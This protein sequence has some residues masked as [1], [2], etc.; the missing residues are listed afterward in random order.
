MV[1]HNRGYGVQ[2]EDWLFEAKITGH[3]R[4]TGQ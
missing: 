2:L 3:Y 4:Y 1:I